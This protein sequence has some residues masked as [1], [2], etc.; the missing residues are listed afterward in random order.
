MGSRYE[1][2]SY[3]LNIDTGDC[4]IHVLVTTAANELP[5]V[6]RAILIDGGLDN[7]GAW[8]INYF[9]AHVGSRYKDNTSLKFDGIVIT[10]WDSDH[11]SGITKLFDKDF[12]DKWE[13]AKKTLTNQF[14]DDAIQDAW[15]KCLAEWRPEAFCKYE[16]GSNK[17]LTHLYAPY[18]AANDSN[19]WGVFKD[20][21]IKGKPANWHMTDKHELQIQFRGPERTTSVLGK[22][23]KKKKP[24]PKGPKEVRSEPLALIHIATKVK[25]K[26]PVADAAD[27][28][29]GYDFFTGDK[30]VAGLTPDAI[31]HPKMVSTSLNPG[32]APVMFCVAADLLVCGEDLQQHAWK[33]DDAAQ[34]TKWHLE[35]GPA[36]LEERRHSADD[37]GDVT[38]SVIP[39]R[40]TT[41]RNEASIACLV[42][43]P[44]QTQPVLTHYL[45]GDMSERVEHGVLKWTTIPDAG[46]ANRRTTTQCKAVKLSHHGAKQSTP[47]ELFFALDPEAV[48]VSNGMSPTHNHP[49]VEI[50]LAIEAWKIW[51][52]R[53]NVGTTAPELDFRA[54]NY[55]V[56]LV[57]CSKAAKDSIKKANDAAAATPAV[58]WKWADVDEDSVDPGSVDDIGDQRF[59]AVVTEL[60]GKKPDWWAQYEKAAAL[61]TGK[62]EKRILLKCVLIAYLADNWNG[63][64]SKL[65]KES[66]A[67]NSNPEPPRHTVA[68]NQSLRAVVITQ[69]AD[70]VLVTEMAFR[71]TGLQTAELGT[72]PDPVTWGHGGRWGQDKA[73]P[74][75]REK[76]GPGRTRLAPTPYKTV[77]PER[78]GKAVTNAKRES[79]EQKVQR[80]TA[81]KRRNAQGVQSILPLPGPS[82]RPVLEASPEA[83]AEPPSSRPTKAGSSSA[84]TVYLIPPGFYMDDTSTVIETQDAELAQFLTYLKAPCFALSSPP[85]ASPGETGVREIHPTDGVARWLGGLFGDGETFPL[86]ADMVGAV[87]VSLGFRTTIGHVIDGGKSRGGGLDISL[88]FET[89]AAPYVLGLPEQSRE[90][91][92]TPSPAAQMLVFGLQV[93]KGATT[94]T[95]TLDDICQFLGVGLPPLL[96][97]AGSVPFQADTSPGVRNAVWF[98]PDST[99][100]TIMRLECVHDAEKADSDWMAALLG[101]ICEAAHIRV[102]EPARVVAKKRW[103]WLGDGHD[104][105]PAVQALWEL[106]FLVT[107]ELTNQQGSKRQFPT[108]LVA[109]SDSITW[110]VGL[111]DPSHPSLDDLCDFVAGLFTSDVSVPSLKV[112]LPAAQDIY[113][114]R[115]IFTYHGGQVSA[116]VVFE[117]SVSAASFLITLALSKGG[118]SF[119]GKLFPYTPDPEAQWLHVSPHYEK[120]LALLPTATGRA[121]GTMDLDALH[122][123]LT[124][125]SAMSQTPLG[126]DLLDLS[127]DIDRSAISFR[128]TIGDGS[129]RGAT[130][131]PRPFP[132]IVLGMA[133]LEFEY[134]FAT[135]AV[136]ARAAA[137]VDL[138]PRAGVAEEPVTLAVTVSYDA[139]A[140]VLHGS[141]TDLSF[142]YLYDLFDAGCNEEVMNMMEFISI[143]AM[144]VTYRYGGG[145]QGSSI[146]VVGALR[147]GPLE[148]D[149]EYAHTG[150]GSWDFEAALSLESKGRKATLLDIINALCGD[151][152]RALPLPECLTR[153]PIASDSDATSP[154]DAPALRMTMHKEGGHFVLVCEARVPSGVTITFASMQKTRAAVALAAGPGQPLPATTRVL[155]ASL[156]P[157]ESLGS[158]KPFLASLAQPFDELQ[159]LWVQSGGAG[160]LA[161]DEVSLINGC[162]GAEH[163]IRVQRGGSGRREKPGAQAKVAL[164]DGCHVV[165][166]SDAEA[167]LDYNFLKGKQPARAAGSL[168]PLGG[169]KDAGG[170]GSGSAPLNKKIGPLSVSDISLGFSNNE[171]RIK[172]SATARLGTFNVSLIGLTIHIDMSSAGS[173]LDLQNASIHL[174]LQGMGLGLNAPPL[175]IAGMLVDQSVEPDID[176]LGGA[177]V[178]FKN[179]SL[180]GL[181]RYSRVQT[182]LGDLVS[183][184]AMVQVNGPLAQIG[185][186]QISGVKVGFGYNTAIKKPDLESVYRFPFCATTQS[187]ADAMAL[188]TM[189]QRELVSALAKD[190]LAILQAY[191]ADWFTS[192]RDHTWIAMGLE[193]MLCQVIDISAAVLVNIT[194]KVS[195]SVY[196][197]GSVQLPMLV[198]REC[199]YLSV[200]LGL[201]AELNFEEGSLIVRSELGPASFILTKACHLT[202]GFALCSW[203]GS[204]ALAGD[205]V[206]S[207]GG[208]HPLYR[209][210]PH[211]PVPSRLGISWQVSNTVN[212]VGEA[213]L[214]MTPHAV[215]A[216]VHLLAEFHSSIIFA[217]FE[218]WADFLVNFAPFYFCADI[219]ISVTAGIQTRILGFNFSLRG[220]ASALLRLEGPPLRGVAEINMLSHTFTVAFGAPAIPAAAKAPLTFNK[221][222]ALVLSKDEELE[223][224]R[225]TGRFHTM[226]LLS[227]S[228][229]VP[230]DSTET[231]QDTPWTV[232]GAAFSFEVQCIIPLATCVVDSAAAQQDPDI[233]SKHHVYSKPMQR[234]VG[235]ELDSKLTIQIRKEG[236]P[237]PE[238]FRAEA[239]YTHVPATLWGAYNPA[240]DPLLQ[241]NNIDKLLSTDQGSS[242][243]TPMLTSVQVTA[244][245][246][247][248][249]EDTLK[250][251]P[252]C[253]LSSISVV[254]TPPTLPSQPEQIHGLPAKMVMNGAPRDPNALPHVRWGLE[255]GA[256]GRGKQ[257]AGQAH[258]GEGVDVV[259][260]GKEEEEEED[261]WAA[262]VELWSSPKLGRVRTGI[263]ELAVSMF[264]W[265]EDTFEGMAPNSRL[266]I[267][268]FEEA[269]LEPPRM[270]VVV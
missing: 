264:G 235:Q 191:A 208:Y 243:G 228:L 232:R 74:P 103:C 15:E 67:D 43:W 133:Q 152:E 230:S 236:K 242:A 105:K 244:P 198:P 258:V 129:D 12:Q 166:I 248:T 99:Y 252:K 61:L 124:G 200:Q 44:S 185:P 196:A 104:A 112:Y 87:P 119:H 181:G 84:G 107:V 214:A 179:Y 139:G 250:A 190:P 253:L 45:A 54:T 97:L 147:L 7:Y 98:I 203:F 125:G 209:V 25:G 126:M 130:S 120:H 266:L 64:I 18:W 240:T 189:A 175:L 180:A 116:E 100:T 261:P 227:G 32:G 29:L 9:R 224:E 218:A 92:I 150:S 143:P 223:N 131:T 135:K 238:R 75:P 134:A 138:W 215:M 256:Q 170:E 156:S 72:V 188:T 8:W 142:A 194:P 165:V 136:R 205:W 49:K 77:F 108:T 70:A 96:T 106:T 177:V 145:S 13:T 182:S 171:L 62:D 57:M 118:P 22:T 263:A 193:V 19:T 93:P 16:A 30:A 260:G 52:T 53:T 178:G 184:F 219:G 41:R 83:K 27:R 80:K 4:A 174:S 55:P 246:P 213:Y 60:W 68:T 78:K 186:A 73:K 36:T 231:S 50:L 204:S 121:T 270:A 2:H 56:Y 158:D 187:D 33:R 26:P 117:V 222:L 202:G 159:F 212:L 154:G 89:R 24:K 220:H 102:C 128:G 254:D 211:Y 95:L 21:D 233:V 172:L 28:L 11:F 23:P 140:W 207:V 206:F 14:D 265:S 63:S 201:I 217:T 239:T 101:K 226:N 141:V 192:A 51:K 42:I 127:L 149:F 34:P 255:W 163:K 157:L 216:G 259:S 251:F 237:F 113:P 225:P 81:Q 94:L 249:V 31:K 17:P 82:E 66:Y 123:C 162:L 111:E 85:P 109:G 115:L 241:G 90:P 47:W 257:A 183:F 245:P 269:Y 46:N 132:G 197:Q 20:K 38:P 151:A 122:R 35:E 110:I 229:P 247:A 88:A 48:V 161:E 37:P 221:L 40:D 148:L 6:Q 167:I 1:V 267:G 168:V 114:R 173:L 91:R 160:G 71:G 164:E 155:I 86:L 39:W 59:Q 234:G 195:L 176:Y 146:Q 3:H 5:T 10:H 76:A 69:T 144:S 169:G 65:S 58:S 199:V 262:G 153:I 79:K 210:P 268:R 137:S